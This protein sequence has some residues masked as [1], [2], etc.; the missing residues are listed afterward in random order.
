[1]TE[2]MSLIPAPLRSQMLSSVH[3][4]IYKGVSFFVMYH[5]GSVVVATLDTWHETKLICPRK[6][7]TS[8]TVLGSGACRMALTLSSDIEIRFSRGSVL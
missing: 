1:M 5:N 8:E 2:S 7:R 3:Y 6:L 4:R